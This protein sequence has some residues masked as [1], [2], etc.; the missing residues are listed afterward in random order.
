MAIMKSKKIEIFFTII[1]LFMIIFFGFRLFWAAC[2][3]V[4]PR[5][6]R[7]YA[8]IQLTKA[9]IDGKNPYVI[10]ENPLDQF[11]YVYTPANS[12]VIAGIYSLT[13]INI[14]TLHYLMDA[15]YIVMSAVLIGVCVYKKSKNKL[16]MLLSIF[17]GLT[18]G[19][20]IGFVSAIPDHLG[21]LVSIGIYMLLDVKEMSRN[22]ILSVSLL[23]IFLFYIKQYYVVLAIPIMAYLILTQKKKYAIEYLIECVVG[24]LLSLYIVN[25]F[26]PLFTLYTFYLFSVENAGVSGSQFEY[27]LLQMKTLICCFGVQFF[28]ILANLVFHIIK[29]KK[30]ILSIWN[31]SIIC[32][33]VVLLYLGKNKGAYL[34]YHLQLLG[35]GLLVYTVLCV[36]DF[37]GYIENTRMLSCF[38]N[39]TLGLCLVFYIFNLKTLGIPRI[40]TLEDKNQWKAAYDMVKA[41]GEQEILLL[42][43]ELGYLRIDN[44]NITVYGNGHNYL[45][46]LIDAD[47]SSSFFGPILERMNLL[48]SFDEL[49]ELACE[50][51]S[52]IDSKIRNKEYAAIYSSNANAEK[53]INSDYSSIGVFDLRT[54]SQ[55]WSVQ[56]YK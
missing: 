33:L 15:I 38:S 46:R 21:L 42:T 8:N 20:R 52:M 39:I 53:L 12:I 43:P 1:L 56:C 31:I 22:R 36:E 5:E 27:S 17:L 54:G 30:I 6:L 7:D 49:K 19:Y 51:N 34:S 28:V 13:K 32:M 25:Y 14:V 35:P 3:T 23:S 55:I 10:N 24:G 44:E 2:S 18:L 41:D 9:I 48:D 16:W 47:I 26:C 11:V 45:N 4:T 50:R 29:K 40:Y 37:G